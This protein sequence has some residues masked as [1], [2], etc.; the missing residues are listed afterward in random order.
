MSL[1]VNQLDYC[2]VSDRIFSLPLGYD[3]HYG[4]PISTDI[5]FGLYEWLTIGGHFDALLLAKN[6]QT[7]RVKTAA[8]QSQNEKGQRAKTAIRAVAVLAKRAFYE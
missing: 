6:D 2:F 8:D 7:V 1:L 4:F 3:G 5:G